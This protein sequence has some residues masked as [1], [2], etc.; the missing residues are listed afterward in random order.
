MRQTG[1]RLHRPQLVDHPYIGIVDKMLSVR[2]A[3]GLV[4]VYKNEESD[5]ALV[6]KCDHPVCLVVYCV[7]CIDFF[8][9]ITFF[10]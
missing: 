5:L 9:F 1:S 8:F 10:Y 4:I 6:S 3:Y 2:F 7:F